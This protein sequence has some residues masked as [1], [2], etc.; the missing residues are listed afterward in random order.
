MVNRLEVNAILSISQDFRPSL[1]ASPSE[2]ESRIDTNKRIP[3]A[4][5]QDLMPSPGRR[6][7]EDHIKKLMVDASIFTSQTHASRLSESEET[8]YISPTLAK[9]LRSGKREFQLTVLSQFNWA[10]RIRRPQLSIAAKSL[11]KVCRVYEPSP[12]AMAFSN[13][14]LQFKRGPKLL[15]EVTQILFEEMA[16]L[17]EN[18]ALLMKGRAIIQFLKQGGAA[19]VE[20]SNRFVDQ[21]N[22]VLRRIRGV[23]WGLAVIVSLT[24]GAAGIVTGDP[25]LEAIGGFGGVAVAVLD[26]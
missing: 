9:V 18:S 17:R 23:S 14:Y 16:F 12:G 3:Q 5:I 11:A 10:W 4:L 13:Q 24:S 15:P 1:E 2:S 22:D 19:I 8:L 6:R 7:L 21:K 20:A 25:L 26:P